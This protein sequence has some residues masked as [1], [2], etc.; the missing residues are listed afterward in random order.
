MFRLAKSKELN[1]SCKNCRNSLVRYFT[2][3]DPKNCDLQVKFLKIRSFAPYF[4]GKKSKELLINL[5][6]PNEGGRKKQTFVEKKKLY[7]LKKIQWGR[8][9]KQEKH[10][11]KQQIDKVSLSSILQECF[12]RSVSYKTSLCFDDLLNSLQ[13]SDNWCQYGLQHHTFN[14][15]CELS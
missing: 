2:F 6:W 13:L 7:F 8:K 4:S 15:Y 9:N 12:L 11:I 3:W 5:A 10:T 14:C 1:F